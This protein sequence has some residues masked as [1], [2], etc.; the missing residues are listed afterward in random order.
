MTLRFGDGSL[1]ACLFTVVLGLV[2]NN[3]LVERSVSGVR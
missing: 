3:V 2:R 1:K